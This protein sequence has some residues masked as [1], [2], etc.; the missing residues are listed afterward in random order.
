[1]RFNN[2]IIQMIFLFVEFNHIMVLCNKSE[3]IS[4]VKRVKESTISD[5]LNLMKLINF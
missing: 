3:K 5:I 1:M 2:I 4:T